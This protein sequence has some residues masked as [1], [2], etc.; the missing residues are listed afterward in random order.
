MKLEKTQH[1]AG[2]TLV[3]MDKIIP[4]FK[5]GKPDLGESIVAKIDYDHS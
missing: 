5:R 1:T 2:L 3:F 4:P